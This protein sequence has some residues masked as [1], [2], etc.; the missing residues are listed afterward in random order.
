VE[1]DLILYRHPGQSPQGGEPGSPETQALAA[2]PDSRFA[3]S[4]MTN[5]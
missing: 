1:L 4:G 2:I 5:S 3:T